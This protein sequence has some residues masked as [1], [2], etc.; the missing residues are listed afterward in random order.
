MKKITALVVLVLA[1]VFPFYKIVNNRVILANATVT[2]FSDSFETDDFSNW[3]STDTGWEITSTQANSGNYKAATDGNPDVINASLLKSTSTTGY[4]NLNFSYWCKVGN[5]EADDHI[6]VEWSNDGSLWYQLEDF[7]EGNENISSWTQKTYLLPIGASNTSNFQFRFR[8][9]LNGGDDSFKLDDVLLTGEPIILPTPTPEPTATPEPTVTPTPKPTATLEPTATP[10]E[11]PTATPTEIPSPTEIPP[12]PTLIPTITP[13]PTPSVGSGSIS[14][15][16]FKDANFNSR[17]DVR[18][19]GLPDWFIFLDL[20]CNGL[21]DISDPV[22]KT[23]E[24]GYYQFTDLAPDIY[25]VRE[26]MKFGWW[27]TTPGFLFGKHR[28]MV[29][30]GAEI[31]GKDFG[32]FCWWSLLRY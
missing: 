23:D 21:K 28:V 10:T 17:K 26:I 32:N 16:V 30:Q 3:D 1:I 4:Q 29:G 2:L 27:Q 18:E 5:P 12:T 15:L 13:T 8:A 9:T 19:T 7:T 31:T 24:N 14:G 11:M 6:L 22:K 20:N 25:Y